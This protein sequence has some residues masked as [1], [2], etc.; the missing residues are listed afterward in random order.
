MVRLTLSG[1]FVKEQAQRYAIA[2]K[3]REPS[4]NEVVGIA[5]TNEAVKADP[6]IEF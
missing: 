4:A 1:G 3:A 5:H 6:L 2:W